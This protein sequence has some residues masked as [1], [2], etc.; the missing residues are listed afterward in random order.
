MS[1]QGNNNYLSFGQKQLGVRPLTVW[2][3]GVTSAE[4][5]SS[6]KHAVPQFSHWAAAPT[7]KTKVSREQR[8]IRPADT[9]LK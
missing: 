3:R 8:F 1:V 7:Y 2:P 4:N 9:E 6:W 5:L